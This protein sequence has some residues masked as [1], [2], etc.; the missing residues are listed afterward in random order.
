MREIGDF[1]RGLAFVAQQS[2]RC[3]LPVSLAG[4]K[5]LWRGKTLRVRIGPPLDPPP[6]DARK[7]AQEAWSDA[8]RATLE[9]LIPPEPPEVPLQRRRWPW[10][11][12]LFN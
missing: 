3:V 10:L 12:D 9:E 11:T 5:P 2:E 7:A 4:S 1:R 6:M 8:L